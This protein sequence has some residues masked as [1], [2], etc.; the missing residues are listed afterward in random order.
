M[1]TL[2][3]VGNW[4]LDEIIVDEQV[5]YTVCHGEVTRFRTKIL[6]DAVKFMH[7]KINFRSNRK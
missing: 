7:E 5:F 6:K 4:Y 3:S 1:Q 2:L